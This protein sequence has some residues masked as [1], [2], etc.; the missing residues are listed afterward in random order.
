M[1]NGTLPVWMLRKAHFDPA[2][3][4]SA[5][6][7]R[8]LSTVL[9]ARFP[10]PGEA[11]G[12]ITAQQAVPPFLIPELAEAGKL[13]LKHARN[14]RIF[15]AGDYDADG[16]CATA[17]LAL[18]LRALGAEASC[19]LPSRADGYGFSL[20]AVEKAKE[21]G[22][23]LV[24]AVDCGTNDHESCRA[25]REAGMDV[26]VVDHHEVK[27]GRPPANCFVNPRHHGMDQHYC[28]AGLVY[29]VVEDMAARTPL[30]VPPDLVVLAAIATVADVMPL[31]GE[32]RTIVRRGMDM[33]PVAKLP[34]LAALREVLGLNH[35]CTRHLGYDVG[36]LLNAPGRLGAPDPALE[37]LLADD[38]ERALELA[39]YLREVNAERQE[40]EAEIARETAA[41]FEARAGDR[42]I[43][44]AD[45]RIPAGMTGIVAANAS[46]QYRRPVVVFSAA[47]EP[48]RGSA[49]APAGYNLVELIREAGKGLPVKFGGHRTAA[50]ITIEPAVFEELRKNLLAVAPPP[51]PRTVE[52]DALLFGGRAVTADEVAELGYL[53][54][55][56]EGNPEP[57]FLAR[58]V[59][60]TPRT[61]RDGRH[62]LFTVENVRF[63]WWGGA[64]ALE[65]LQQ[66]LDIACTLQPDS[67][68]GTPRVQAK[69]V[70]VAPSIRLTRDVVRAVYAAASSGRLNEALAKGGNL[71][72][73]ALAALQELGV[74]EYDRGSGLL[75]P[76]TVAGGTSLHDSGIFR[77]YQQ[78]C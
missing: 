8:L 44:V 7:G 48:W 27:H 29:K 55:F 37:L 64:A 4:E 72:E 22:A 61:T 16:I 34:G 31:C 35:V 23:S 36:P 30:P 11:Y 69:V 58:G 21:A 66:P 74:L 25:A 2:E 32:N 43:I 33:W 78:A 1:R 19:Y 13:I 56:G 71:A 41:L 53:A 5:G 57:L 46:R 15:I 45:S 18:W 12:F 68:S 40:L 10:T 62:V 47:E 39:R 3:L 52:V 26:V 54:P 9:A 73:V 63:V 70:H 65:G 14:G 59:Q 76:A 51:P 20:K 6:L 38:Q 42:I 75:R 77:A 67:Y 50:G 49:R 28:A 60:F 17:I 24:V